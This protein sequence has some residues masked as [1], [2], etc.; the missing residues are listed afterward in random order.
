MLRSLERA[1][2]CRGR[3]ALKQRIWNSSSEPLVLLKTTVPDI[4]HARFDDTIGCYYLVLATKRL[5]SRT[6]TATLL[7]AAEKDVR[8]ADEFLQEAKRY[9]RHWCRPGAWVTK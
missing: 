8:R 7:T 6:L 1:A 2:Y 3:D 9:G 4:W 5:A